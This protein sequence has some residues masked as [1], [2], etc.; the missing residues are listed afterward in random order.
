MNTYY[1]DIKTREIL[2]QTGE[3]EKYIELQNV[4]GKHFTIKKSQI[5]KWFYKM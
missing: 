5:N 3:N 4:D 2:V 1:V